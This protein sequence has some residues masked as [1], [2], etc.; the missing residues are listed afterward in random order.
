[1]MRRILSFPKRFLRSEK[2]SSTVEFV[3]AF[4][5]II[6]LMLSGIELGFVTLQHSML[7]RAM[8]MTVREI[9]LGTGTAPQHDEI[10]QRICD[11]AGFIANCNDALRLEMVQIDPR[12]WSA[13]DPNPDC[14]DRSQE[15]APVRNF[16]NGQE[17]ELM[18]LRACVRIDPV[19]PTT[20]LGS[21]L[22]KGPGGQYALISTTA[23]VQEP[24]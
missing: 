24:R 21:T 20:G 14:I 9:R 16:V 6:T 2:G 7:E 15:V 19:F 13:V 5:A 22:A 4:P 18:I 3:I 10:K 8:D 12:A 11:R 17:N 23:F 1:M